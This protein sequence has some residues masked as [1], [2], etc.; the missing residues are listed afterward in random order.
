M[1]EMFKRLQLIFIV[2]SGFMLLATNCL[3]SNKTI[4]LL[5][6]FP[7]HLSLSTQHVNRIHFANKP[8][9]KIIGD[10]SKYNIILSENRKDLFIQLNTQAGDRIN[11]SVIDIAGKVVDLEITAITSK[12]PSIITL[13]DTDRDSLK[14]SDAEREI[15]QML[16][17]MQQGI[18]SKYYVLKGSSSFNCGVLGQKSNCQILA[19]YRFGKYRGIT[20]RV[21]NKGSSLLLLDINS[22]AKAIPYRILRQSPTSCVIA[23]SAEKIIY[24]VGKVGLE[25]D[26]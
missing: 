5:Y 9:W 13:T 6:D 10:T 23:K 24:F 16:T 18:K 22:L 26:V 8:A 12:Y 14:D 1:R 2:M 21:R 19:D 17:A 25:D 7:T 4:E 11:I 15:N 3:A 20:L